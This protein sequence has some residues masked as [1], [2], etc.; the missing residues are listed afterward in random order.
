MF[1]I[2]FWWVCYRFPR[3]VYF[4]KIPRHSLYYSVLPWIVTTPL[5]FARSSC[6]NQLPYRMQHGNQ[7]KNT[8]AKILCDWKSVLIRQ[9]DS[10]LRTLSEPCDVKAT[11]STMSWLR[12]SAGDFR[13]DLI[14]DWPRYMSAYSL[15]ER[16]GSPKTLPTCDSNAAPEGSDHPDFRWPVSPSSP[17]TEPTWTQSRLR[18]AN[19]T[20]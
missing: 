19:P 13:S 16:C 14:L 20:S 4:F 10:S 11:S 18:F 1:V 3:N 15:A 8:T 7:N 9:T 12:L 5:I 2:V 17:V 6:C